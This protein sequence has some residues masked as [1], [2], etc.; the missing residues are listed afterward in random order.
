MFMN[1]RV[2]SLICFAV[3]VLSSFANISFADENDFNIDGT[4]EAALDLPRILFLLKRDPNEPALEPIGGY[5][6]PWDWDF[7]WD[8]IFGYG[9][10]DMDDLFGGSLDLGLGSFELNWAY[11]DTGVS[12]ILFSKETATLMDIEIDPNGQYVDPG[13][14]GEEYFDIS[15]PLYLGVA[16]YDDPEPEDQSH[17]MLNGPYRAMVRQ[18]EAEG[19]FEEPLDILGMPVMFGRTVVFNTR[20]PSNLEYFTARIREPND[21]A[22]PDVDFEVPIRF[23]KYAMPNDPRQI[24][25]LPVLAYNPVI[26]NITVEDG[27][28]SSSGTFIFDTGGM[29][30]LISEAQAVNLG[31]FDSNG[32]LIREPDFSMPVGGIGDEGA[33]EIMGYILDRLIVPTLN[34]YNLVYLNARVGVQD[35]SILDETTGELITL[36]GIFGSNFLVATAEITTLDLADTP[37]DNVVLDTQRAVLG[38]DVNDLYVLPPS[39]PT[40]G[41]AENPWPEGDLNRDCLVDFLDVEILTG[42]WLDECNWLNWNCSGADLNF[43]GTVDNLDYSKLFI[44]EE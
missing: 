10:F 3:F 25:P 4:F 27:P 34:G 26:D 28:Y 14:A 37:F 8:D 40:C 32:V 36:D 17:Y 6:D 42:R 41:D 29:I 1:S 2:T 20:A 11:L 39:I 7:D 35:I 38:F 22:I 19:L 44:K 16:D 33:V 18:N 15:E 13:V 5:D 24:P 31:L 9:G 23:E 30:S 21:P 43:D 12:S